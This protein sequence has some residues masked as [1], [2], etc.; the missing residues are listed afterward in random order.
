MNGLRTTALG[1]GLLTLEASGM[2]AEGAPFP[3]ANPPR[4]PFVARRPRPDARSLYSRQALRE[5]RAYLRLRM[6]EL[7]EADLDRVR[8]VIEHRLSVD[9]LIAPDAAGAERPR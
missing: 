2:A 8:L 9:D 1:I 3:H 6:L 5:M 4:A 7:R